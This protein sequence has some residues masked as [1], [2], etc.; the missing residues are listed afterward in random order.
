MVFE[1]GSTA[2]RSA[3]F[4]HSLLQYSAIF[5]SSIPIGQVGVLTNILALPTGAWPCN[6]PS[7]Q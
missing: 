7:K 4:I 5:S 2:F 6:C 1:I 3:F